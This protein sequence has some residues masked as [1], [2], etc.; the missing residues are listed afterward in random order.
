MKGVVTRVVELHHDF[1]STLSVQR[2]ENKTCSLP[3]SNANFTICA[4]YDAKRVALSEVRRAG[5]LFAKYVD[6]FCRGGGRGRRD[7]SV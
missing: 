3:E 5:N 1:A 6:V 4:S 2:F 7:D